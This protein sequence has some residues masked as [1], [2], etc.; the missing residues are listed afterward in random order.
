MQ[1]ICLMCCS[2]PHWGWHQRP[3]RDA[4]R[5]GERFCARSVPLSRAAVARSRSVVVSANVQVPQVLLLQE[6]C[7]QALPS[8]VRVLLWLLSTGES[9][10]TQNLSLTLA[11][12]L[13]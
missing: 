4:G 9:A 1:C 7:I 10:H 3:G 12:V 5:S 13:P 6:L 8:L 11:S 2:G